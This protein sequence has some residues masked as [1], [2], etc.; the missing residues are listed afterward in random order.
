[1]HAAE[2]MSDPEE[3]WQVDTPDRIYYNSGFNNNTCFFIPEWNM[4]FVHMVID[5]NPS[6]PKH[7]AYNEFFKRFANAVE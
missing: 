5:G 3:Q 4:A 2:K 7:I 6:L 1:M